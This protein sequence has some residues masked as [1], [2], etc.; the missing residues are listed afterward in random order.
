MLLQR[1]RACILWCSNPRSGT[2][3]R[4]Q[5][6]ERKAQLQNAIGDAVDSGINEFMF[7]LNRANYV[8]LIRRQRAFPLLP[9][10]PSRVPA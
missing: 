7:A 10:W 4:P 1:E 2:S 5:G 3:S 8:L 6:Y 9:G